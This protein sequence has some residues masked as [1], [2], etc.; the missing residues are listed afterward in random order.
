MKIKK[1]FMALVVI[2]M[3]IATRVSAYSTETY[4][5]DINESDYEVATENG[6]VVF[7][8]VSGDSIVV[9]EIEQK[10]FGGKLTQYQLN[11]ISKQIAE[12]YQEE[13]QATITE[14]GREET[15]INNHTVTRMKF[16]TTISG[17]VLKQEMNIFVSS[18]RIYDIIFTSSTEDGFSDDEKNKILASFKIVGDEG[19]NANDSTNAENTGAIDQGDFK[20]V[21]ME[22]GIFIA[23]GIVLSIFAIKHNPKNKLYLLS[24]IF[25]IL[26]VFAIKGA[27][28][29]NITANEI[30]SDVGFNIGFF[31]FAIIGIILLIIQLC[32]KPKDK[33]KN[34][35]IKQEQI[36]NIIQEDNEKE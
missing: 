20:F 29:E 2:L 18:D 12:Q 28:I 10:T 35:E 34:E 3:L 4:S 30:I 24:I 33:N 22:L 16:E 6:I 17:M 14:T 36:N 13:F 19:T 21:W 11:V 5:I 27:E 25:I 1:I 15:T 32:L 26:Q 9:Q 7:Q 8:K 23:L 31:V